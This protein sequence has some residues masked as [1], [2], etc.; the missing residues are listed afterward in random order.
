MSIDEKYIDEVPTWDEI[1]EKWRS[2]FQNMGLEFDEFG[3]QDE[4][5]YNPF[6]ECD[7]LGQTIYGR[8]KCVQW[9]LT[10]WSD[11]RVNFAC[12]ISIE[13][14]RIR[15]C[16]PTPDLV[17]RSILMLYELAE[18]WYSKEAENE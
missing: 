3:E 1:Y 10:V 4:V 15:L 14:A 18:Y 17:K 13:K 6:D 7:W 12:E 11:F 5:E 8:Y 16:D 9:A 2:E